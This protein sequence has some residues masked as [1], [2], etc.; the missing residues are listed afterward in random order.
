M[1]YCPD[2]RGEYRTGFTHCKD[3]GLALV[4]RLPAENGPRSHDHHDAA[5]DQSRPT[6]TLFPASP[7]PAALTDT[8]DDEESPEGFL[9]EGDRAW[10]YSAR[11][12]AEAWFL[13]RLLKQSSLEADLEYLGAGHPTPFRLMVDKTKGH[14]AM[15][16]LDSLLGTAPCALCGELG[17]EV[18]S[19]TPFCIACGA[20]PQP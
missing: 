3:C 8:A 1:P 2:C 12:G 11:T 14:D 15:K 9:I 17:P 20:G 5:L 10:I 6:S 4:D 19:E 7:V 16:A 18:G 13:K